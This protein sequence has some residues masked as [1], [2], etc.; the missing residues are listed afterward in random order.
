MISRRTV[1][2][3]VSMFALLAAG[4]VNAFAAPIVTS[5]FEFVG[6]CIDC[7]E[8]AETAPGSYPAYATLVLQNYTQGD[9]I[10]WDNLVS[11]SYGGTNLFAPY[12]ILP[13]DNGSISGMMPPGLP[14]STVNFCISTTSW[15][16]TYG[17]TAAS[18][19]ALAI[20]GDPFFF[21]TLF[22]NDGTFWWTGSDEPLDYGTDYTWNPARGPDQ[23]GQVPEPG[24]YVL[25]GLGLAWL[26]WRRKQRA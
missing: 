14:S 23:G 20:A 11:F 12:A 25:T 10:N 9:S 22:S 2:S 7:A 4:A 24:T 15:C 8:E 13:A 6:S 1:F 16:D 5:T 18:L 17:E 26:A 19:G 3:N 21:E